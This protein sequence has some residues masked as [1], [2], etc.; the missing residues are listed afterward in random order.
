MNGCGLT[1]I[2]FGQFSASGSR[3]ISPAPMNPRPVVQRLGATLV[4]VPTTVQEARGAIQGTARL[5]EQADLAILDIATYPE[6]KAAS[7]PSEALGPPWMPSSRD[8]SHHG[9]NIAHSGPRGAKFLTGDPACLGCDCQHLYGRPDSTDT[10]ARLRTAT[11]LAG[12]GSS[13]SG[14]SIS[15][16]G[17][18]TIAEFFDID[19]VLEDHLALEERFGI[20][21]LPQSEMPGEPDGQ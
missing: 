9:T 17:G 3:S 1:G 15:I 7:A 21:Q 10:V 18:G 14:A 8:E 4:V 12:A 19:V 20:R 13:A 5:N 11:S 2:G 16:L 6:G